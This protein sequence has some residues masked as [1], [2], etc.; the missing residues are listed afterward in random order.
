MM[1]HCL[2]FV[3]LK[4]NLLRRGRCN[5]CWIRCW[6][7]CILACIKNPVSK[8]I[9]LGKLVIRLWTMTMTIIFHITRWS[10]PNACLILMM[11]MLTL[12]IITDKYQWWWCDGDNMQFIPDS[13]WREEAQRGTNGTGMRSSNKERGHWNHWRLKCIYIRQNYRLREQTFDILIK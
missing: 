7:K 6:W 12:L 4:K 11:I 9:H 3:F 5:K 10:L 8:L 13:I 2:L 1:Y